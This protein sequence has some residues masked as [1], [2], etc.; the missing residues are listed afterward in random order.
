MIDYI[1]NFGDTFYSITRKFNIETGDLLAV[2]PD[3]RDPDIITPGQ[4]I[5]IPDHGSTGRTISVNGFIL[6]SV[7]IQTLMDRL[8]YLTYLSIFGYRFNTDAVLIDINDTVFIQMSLTA[9]VAPMMVISNIDEN[10]NY[11]AELAH[12]ILTDSQ[13][14]RNLI[15]NIVD[16]LH[17]KN[18]YG[19]NLNFEYLY[20]SDIF[21][22]SYFANAVTTALRPLGY[23]VQLSVRMSVLKNQRAEI[24][25]INSTDSLREI[26]QFIIMS[27][28]LSYTFGQTM[29]MSPLDQVQRALD[30]AV[31]SVPRLKILLGIP[32]ASYN[33]ALPRNLGV[34]ARLLSK[35][36][37]IALYRSTSSIMQ[38]D[39]I[40]R[41]SYFNY[42]DDSGIGHIVWIEDGHG[43]EYYI[44]LVDTYNLNGVSLW[45]IDLF[46]SADYQMLKATHDI[47]KVISP[48]MERG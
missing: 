34:P 33:W 27:N 43:F 26:D 4:T 36:S 8:P 40:T 2:N 11:S 39:A 28:E 42:I 32:N 41:G 13:L 31:I 12:T 15:T 25:E 37:A 3:I 35:E 47:R 45:T 1:V 44:Q 17:N 24:E 46:T 6:L 29:V 23:I 30:A 22:Y 9:G 18:Y 16:T 38:V 5:K 48:A 20:P 21:A 10:G 19:L 7:D 14:R